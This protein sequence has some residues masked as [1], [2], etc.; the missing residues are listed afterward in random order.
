MSTLAINY[1]RLRAPARRLP[2]CRCVLRQLIH[3]GLVNAAAGSFPGKATMY[4]SGPSHS[5]SLLEPQVSKFS[6]SVVP[7]VTFGKTET[8]ETLLRSRQRTRGG[9]TELATAS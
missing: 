7:L 5:S 4:I 9:P 1:S 2:D 3:P 6:T 8:V